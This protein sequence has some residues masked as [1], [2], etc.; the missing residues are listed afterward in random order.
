[1][2]QRATTIAATAVLA[3]VAV[4][5][6]AAGRLAPYRP[7]QVDLGAVLAG[8]GGHHL[9][10]G[11][12]S[13]RDVLTLLL[14]GARDSLLG[15][16]LATAVAL[17][18][19]GTTGLLAGYFGRWV[20][21]VAS[22]VFSLV[23]ALPAVIVVLAYVAVVGPGLVGTMV[24]VGMLMSPS[25][26][27]I[28]RVAA[29]RVRGELYI[30]AARVAGLSD[31]RIVRRHVLAAVRS[32]IIVQTPLLFGAALLLQA[33]IEFI[34]LGRPGSV[35]WGAMLNGASASVFQAPLL[36]V[37]PGLA[38]AVTVLAVTLLG[39]ALRDRVEGADVAAPRAT[40]RPAPGPGAACPDALLAVDGLRVC[41]ATRHG[42]AVVV[43]G[44]SLAV[45]RGEVVGL[46]GESGSGKT[47]TVLAAL[48]LLADSGRAVAGS[49]RFDGTQLLG[50]PDRVV[51]RLRGRRIGYV[52]QEPMSNLDP[53]FRAGTQLTE[54]M[55]VHLGLS[56]REA[57]RRALEL[58]ARV[59][60][61]DPRR[62][63]RAYPHEISGGTAQRVLIAAAISC[64]PDLIVADEPTTALDVT[65]QAEVLDLLRGLR[66]ERGMAVL[67]VTH[68][69]G[70]VADM[71][72]RVVVM[73]RGRIVESAPVERLFAGPADPYTAALL[74][75]SQRL[76][77]TPRVAL[78][79]VDERG[80]LLEVDRLCVEFPQRGWRRAPLPV[81]RQ[82][83]LSVHEGETVGLVG[84]SGSGKTTLGRAVLGLVPVAGGDIRYQGGSIAHLGRA[85]RRDLSGQIQAVFQDPFSSLNP[86]MRIHDILVEPLLVAGRLA[87]ADA[88]ARI[89]RLLDQVG[90]P[91]DV[92]QRRA[93]E[94]SGGQR[95][96]VAIARAL[97]L[98]PRLII[99]D[100]PVSS[101]DLRT[102][103]QVLDLLNEIQKETGVAYLFISHDLAVVRAI[104]DRV[105]VMAG[106][107]IVET[108]EA[109]RVTTQPREPY[110]R[111]LLLSALVADPV[112]QAARRAAR[113]GLVAVPRHGGGE[114]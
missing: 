32:V 35:S 18:V 61:T 10:G 90:L 71:C 94:L 96:R 103:A 82:V 114:L 23:L 76:V 47:Q 62:V 108:D 34:G 55:R 73:N 14:F 110:T 31:L 102:Q 70:V 86:S 24:L 106:G 30:D 93:R 105:A 5:A 72:D 41:H 21:A 49:V 7:D 43:D 48:G 104:C 81:L 60:I 54:P 85:G 59:G 79:V 39:N 3:A 57:R 33:G 11:D 45:R 50:Q 80:A 69:L 64:D 95:Q 58:L 68:D 42:E 111:R 28:V 97:A 20:D 67:L 12:G 17:A 15:A 87:R 75:A 38:I 74:A 22:W 25:I 65:V 99:C 37:W 77:A 78:S 36:S 52:S 40:H 88:E 66:A 113:Q 27:R 112:Q 2:R 4:A 51:N 8:P 44:V 109:R 92:G 16:V 107:E 100:E 89:R 91:A 9:L 46:V 19:G 63:F 29:Q 56:R 1:M 83:S 6:A 101:L 84:E 98:S 26:Y 53:S 13:G